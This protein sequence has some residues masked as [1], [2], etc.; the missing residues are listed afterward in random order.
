MM[1]SIT[2]MLLP[3]F[4]VQIYAK[5]LVANR[6]GDLQDSVDSLVDKLL[7]KVFSQALRVSP[8][9]RTEIDNA[10]LGQLMLRSSR[11]SPP[12]ALPGPSF[13]RS[14]LPSAL[15]MSGRFRPFPS[16]SAFQ[17]AKLEEARQIVKARA[18]PEE[19][20]SRAALREEV[21]YPFAKVRLY[22]GAFLAVQALIASL[23]ATTK[24]TASLA[25]APRAD[26]VEKSAQTLGIDVACLVGLGLFTNREKGLADK[27]LQKFQCEENLS[28]LTVELPNRKRVSLLDFQGFARPIIVSTTEDKLVEIL[29]N[30][31]E[32]KE[33]LINRGAFIVPVVQ[34]SAQAEEGQK[35]DWARWREDTKEKEKPFFVKPIREDEWTQ[36]VQQQKEIANVDADA[37]VWVSLR[38]DG[39]VRQSGKGMPPMAKIVG[40]LPLDSGTFGG[41]LDGMDG[42]V[43]R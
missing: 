1:R 34:A 3:V 29:K 9:H 20:R 13:P 14:H 26:P 22:G 41:F 32:T 16:D 36:W 21:A 37:S 10:T 15:S 7:V 17:L 38:K 24:L 5:K 12:S 19:A 11:L 33:D 31:E 40:T 42:A 25:G 30:V 35:L 23:V 8:L 18:D 6:M 4:V 39:R 28:Q 27:R 2:V 43:P